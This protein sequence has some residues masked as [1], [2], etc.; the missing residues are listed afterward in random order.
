MAETELS[1]VL[2]LIDNASAD[3]KKTISGA[4]EGTNKLK[5]ANDEAYSQMAKSI[6][7]NRTVFERFSNSFKEKSAGMVKAL[8]ESSSELKHLGRE[9]RQVGANIA[10]IGGAI[11]SIFIKAL[12]DSSKYSENVRDSLQRLSQVTTQFGIIIANAVVPV[13]NGLT[14]ILDRLVTAFESLSPEL[15]DSILRWAFLSG[16]FITITGV[17]IALGGQFAIFLSAIKGIIAAII[18][19]TAANIALLPSILAIGAEIATVIFLMYKFK[20]VADFVLNVFELLFKN[21]QL[22]LEVVSLAWNKYVA[23]ILDGSSKIFETLAKLNFGNKE[24]AIFFTN[25]ANAASGLATEAKI[26]ADKSVF[27]IQRISKEM[28][29]LAQGKEGSFAINFDKAKTSIDEIVKAINGIGKGTELKILSGNDLQLAQQSLSNFNQKLADQKILFEAGKISADEYYRGLIA[30]QNSSINLNQI[31]SQQLQQMAQLQAEVT[32]NQFLNAQRSTQEQINLLNEYKANFMVAHAG[33]TQLV[34]NLSSSIRTNLA[35]A[36]SSIATGAATAK[37]AFAQ[38]GKTLIGVI[39]EFLAQK[40]IAFALEKTLLAGTVASASAAASVIAAAWAP[41]AFLATVA[42]FGAAAAQA[43]A[44]LA[45]AGAASIAVS[46]GLSA[47]SKAAGFGAGAGGATKFH[48]GG[49]IR[50]H[51]GLAVDEVP[52]IAQTGE[53]VLSR[54][55]MKA[56]GGA[57]ALNQLNRGQSPSNSYGDINL[58]IN[59]NYPQVSKDQEIKKLAEMLGFEIQRQLTYARS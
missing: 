52:I 53:G 14:V 25:A 43:P 15:R 47:A 46:T 41:A 22:Q 18:S 5:S 10:F 37:D 26:S 42:T 12:N 34:T 36:I 20:P 57:S 30:A 7:E 8:Q 45:A 9:I 23:L 13:I 21:I 49:I 1:I 11:S 59:V 48:S 16:I 29:S 27:E 50:A 19:W 58:S 55:G 38:F 35:S 28:L 31:A 44:A 39:V 33:M 32:N 51:D 3:L 4:I 40:V 54:R 6:E 24:L 56:L 2:K 17:L